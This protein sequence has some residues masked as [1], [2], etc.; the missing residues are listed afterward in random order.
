[1]KTIK[2]I[3]LASILFM[4]A[5]VNLS[6]VDV[7]YAQYNYVLEVTDGNSNSS[8]ESA[9]NWWNDVVTSGR[10]ANL[11]N[12]QVLTIIGYFIDI[13]IVVWIAVA[14]IGGYKIMTS[15]KEESM[16]EWIR[17]VVFGIIGI[18]IMASARFLAEWLV[19][20]DGVISGQFV[21]TNPSWIDFSENLYNNIVYPF[22]KIAL[23]FVIWILFF[24]MAGKVIG[25]ATATD[26]SA[27]K[28]AGWII[29]WCVIWILIVMWSKQLVEAVM[30]KQEKVLEA[31]NRIDEQW[32][33]ILEFENIPLITQV[34]NW[35]MG[36]TMLAIVVLII[37]QWYKIFTN[38]DDPKTRES[39]KKAMLYIIIWV[40]VIGASYIISQVLVI[41]RVP[42]IN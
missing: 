13:F 3:L 7:V 16:K 14:F 27:K 25:F 11:F 37:I 33:S 40:L 15:D 8:L 18:I 34:I 31:T 39:L 21:G 4:F 12:D 36:L 26:D 5:S 41:N 42:E 20:G 17:L 1:M 38:P 35:V 22:I 24:V 9:I 19:W 23:Y 10:W 6:V 2:K 28:K 29:I 30:G 32:N